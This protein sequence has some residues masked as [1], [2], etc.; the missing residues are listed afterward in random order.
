MVQSWDQSDGDGALLA[1]F[2]SRLSG[3]VG[4]ALEVMPEVRLAPVYPFGV[5][6][7]GEII[8]IPYRIYH[9]EPNPERERSLSATQ[10]V[11]LAC[12]Y[13][14]HHDG[15][16]RQHRLEQ[17]V[18][19]NDPWIVPFVVQLAGEYVL[20]ILE[21]ILRGLAGLTVPRS[22]QRMLYGEFIVRNPDF[23]A[24]TERR[25]V[26]YWDC[27]YRRK[28]LKFGAYPGSLLLDSFR[29]AASEQAGAAWPRHTPPPL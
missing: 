17:I 25:V 1:A 9:D 11:I 3:D 21:V 16:V 2:P 28:Y 8:S 12:L 18:G 23:F 20:E 27:Y 14:R 4:R 6:V 10:Q 13:S 5:D 22:A 19:V 26:S 24:R 15:R 7:Q 29:D